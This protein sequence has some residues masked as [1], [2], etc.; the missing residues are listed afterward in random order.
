VGDYRA[1]AGQAGRAA[2]LAGVREDG[3]S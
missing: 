3:G 1:D 2:G